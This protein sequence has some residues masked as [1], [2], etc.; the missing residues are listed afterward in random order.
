MYRASRMLVALFAVSALVFGSL[1]YAQE[2]PGQDDPEPQTQPAPQEEEAVEESTDESA[3]EA[4]E[5]AEASEEE[6]I[7]EEAAEPEFATIG[8]RAPNFTLKAWGDDDTEHSLSDHQGKIVVLEWL[9]HACPAWKRHYR[10]KTMLDLAKAYKE[11]NVV[12]LGINSTGESA[13]YFRQSVALRPQQTLTYPELDDRDGTVGKRYKAR[14]T[15]HMFVIDTAGILVYSGA[16]DSGRRSDPVVNYVKQTVDELLAE[17]A[18]S[19]SKT[20]PYG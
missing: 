10:A 17:Q 4:A 15:P 20:R 6:A 9:C 13:G 3:E 12:W 18:V 5:E 16:I 14:T 7:E 1:A 19:T 2:D 11:K 8:Q